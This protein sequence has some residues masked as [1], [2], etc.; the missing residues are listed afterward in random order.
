METVLKQGYEKIL[1]LF[2]S[3]PQVQI[4]LRDIAR[5]AK[6]QG[7][8]AFRF[9]KSLEDEGFLFSRREGNLKKYGLQKND[10]TY[11][12]LA[13]FD[14]MRLHDLPRLRRQAIL[15]FIHSLQEKPIIAF[16]FGSTAKRTFHDQSDIDLL[17]VVNKK[18]N[19]KEAE[20]YA[21]AQTAHRI[22]CI[23]LTVPQFRDE[24]KLQ[25]NQVVQAAIKTGYPITNHFEYYR[26][27]YEGI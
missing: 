2:Y 27:L 20:G 25:N 14:I 13:F 16:V 23:Q 17:L 10:Q 6:L 9:L 26:M 22:H 1:K 12:V 18:I 21:D 3:D 7:N 8:S 4:H 11:A 19:T 15:S 24:L 5:K